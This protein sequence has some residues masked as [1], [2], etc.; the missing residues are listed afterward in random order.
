M[1]NIGMSSW[2]GSGCVPSVIFRMVSA[3]F[4]FLICRNFS[5]IGLGHGFIPGLKSPAR[6]ICCSGTQRGLSWYTCPEYT[7]PSAGGVLGPAPSVPYTCIPGIRAKSADRPTFVNRAQSGH[8][9][10]E[11]KSGSLI[12]SMRD[13][14]PPAV[15][16]VGYVQEMDSGGACSMTRKNP[17][18]V[19]CAAVGTYMLTPM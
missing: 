6:G 17:S 8:L 5:V 15:P 2:V 16:G 4:S 14:G 10:A 12:R 9:I 11:V 3:T 7:K 18:N 13:I 19:T 1:R